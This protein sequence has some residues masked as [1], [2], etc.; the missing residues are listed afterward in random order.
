MIRRNTQQAT[1]HSTANVRSFSQQLYRKLAE[2]SHFETAPSEIADLFALTLPTDQ[3]REAIKNVIHSVLLKVTIEE[4]KKRCCYYSALSYAQW[5]NTGP[6]DPP[7]LTCWPILTRQLII[8]NLQDFIAND[9]NFAF[10]SNIINDYVSR[11]S[12]LKNY[13]RYFSHFPIFIMVLGFLYLHRV[14]CLSAV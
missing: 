9:L 14:K 7:D 3:C 11:C 2:R 12:I 10:Y 4:A 8:E 5:N 13:V 1:S 6:G